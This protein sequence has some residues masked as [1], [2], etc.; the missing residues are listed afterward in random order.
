MRGRAIALADIGAGLGMGLYSPW[1]QWLITNYGWRQAFGILGLSVVALLVPLN[2]WHRATPA[3]PRS[4]S[5]QTP[6]VPETPQETG[7]AWT[8]PLA[9]RTL[10]FWMLFATLLFSNISLQLVNVHLVALLVSMG[11]A[12]MTAAT[13]GGVVNLVSLGGRVACGWLTDS[14]GCEKAYSAAMSCSL[15]G[16]AIL[17][18]MT[19]GNATW[20]LLVFI[21]IFGL[22]KGSGGIVIGAKAADVFHGKHLGTIFGVISGASGLGGALGPWSA[23]WLVDH[24]G[25]YIVAILCSLLTGACAIGC[26]WLVSARKPPA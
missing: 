25:N 19:P 7:P 1:S 10:P 20:M 17:L 12:T 13:V 18:S 23:G 11:V 8:L 4:P 21:G 3:M 16:M 26:M 22:S 6:E 9:L 15:V 2:C 24:T 14:L 5:P